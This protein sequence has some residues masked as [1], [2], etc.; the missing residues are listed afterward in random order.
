MF[1]NWE[2]SKILTLIFL[3][4]I[5]L[6]ICCKTPKNQV[7]QKTSQKQKNKKKKKGKKKGS[8]GKSELNSSFGKEV[9]G[10]APYD[11]SLDDEERSQSDRSPTKKVESQQGPPQKFD[12][13]TRDRHMKY[14]KDKIASEKEDAKSSKFKVKGPIHIPKEATKYDLENQR[15]EAPNDIVLK[16]VYFD[17]KLNERYIIGTDYDDIEL[18]DTTVA[19]STMQQST[20][21]SGRDTIR[22]KKGPSGITLDQTSTVDTKI[23]TIQ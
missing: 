6:S 22:K 15:C 21:V 12:K 16:K 18:D 11:K 20:H 7:K 23:M 14:M 9:D 4:V 8:T 13:A 19:Q 3:T 2:I 10:L 17:E 5:S 1:V